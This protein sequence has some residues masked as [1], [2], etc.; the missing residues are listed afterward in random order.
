MSIRTATD[1]EQD[2]RPNFLRF[3]QYALYYSMSFGKRW[4]S[5]K[6]RNF[7]NIKTTTKKIILLS[8]TCFAKVNVNWKS[9]RLPAFEISWNNFR[10]LLASAVD[11]I[12]K[13]SLPRL[14]HYLDI[15]MCVNG[16][17]LSS[18]LPREYLATMRLSSRRPPGERPVFKGRSCDLRNRKV[19]ETSF[20]FWNHLCF[21]QP[22]LSEDST[23]IF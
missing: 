23:G 7:V 5:L 4:P 2:V 15:T 11:C 3:A 8:S 19:L 1:F 6:D 13:F 14:Y 16:L 10:F 20:L 9:I 22:S 12:R 21:V 18:H 17:C